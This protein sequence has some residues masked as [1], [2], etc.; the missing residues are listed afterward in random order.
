MDGDNITQ[1]I[2]A[3]IGL[4]GICYQAYCSRKHKEGKDEQTKELKEAIK[5]SE[6][7]ADAALNEAQKANNV[8]GEVKAQLTINDTVTVTSVRQ[9]IRRLYHERHKEKT[10]SLVDYSALVEMY[11]AYKSVTLPDGHHPNSWCDALYEEM[12]GWER[13]SEYPG[14]CCPKTKGEK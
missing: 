10:I 13:V 9:Q 8:L 7:K 1:I 12:C 14:H 3:A 4:A 2:I 11:N 5:R 6:D